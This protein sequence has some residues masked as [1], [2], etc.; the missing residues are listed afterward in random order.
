MVDIYSL[1]TSSHPC[2]EEQET[3][4]EATSCSRV[5]RSQRMGGR[6]AAATGVAAPQRHCSASTVA[7]PPAVAAAEATLVVAH[8]L[9]NIPPPPHTSPSVVE[10]W[11]HDIDQLIVAASNTLPHRGWQHFL[12]AHSRTLT[13]ACMP[14]APGALT[15]AHDPPATHAPSAACAPAPPHAPSACAT[16]TELWVELNHHHD[17]EDSH[18]TIER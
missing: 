14:S 5:G 4:G 8:Q 11:H 13:V 6:T 15:Y 18:I 7:T 2:L 1:A 10:Q 16:M 17:G 9:L 3:E 12:A